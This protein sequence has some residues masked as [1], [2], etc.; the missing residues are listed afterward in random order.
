MKPIAFATEVEADE[1]DT[2]TR[3]VMVEADEADDANPLVA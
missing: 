3:C 2:T 1:A